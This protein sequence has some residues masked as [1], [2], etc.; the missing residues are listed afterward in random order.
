LGAVWESIVAHIVLTTTPISLPGGD[1]KT[2]LLLS[3]LAVAPAY[4]NKGIGSQLI[5]AALA[6]AKELGYGAVLLVG[7]P[8]YYQRFGFRPVADFGLRDT[9]EIPAMYV[10]GLEL[11]AGYLDLG[12]GTITIC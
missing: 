7:E 11:V 5:I 9:G 4:Q 8:G 1:S 2:A 10:Q 6:R 3:P 12:G